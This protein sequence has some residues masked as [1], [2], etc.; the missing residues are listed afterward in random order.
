MRWDYVMNYKFLSQGIHVILHSPGISCI[1][2]VGYSFALRFGLQYESIRVSAMLI[3]NVI[4]KLLCRFLF[5]HTFV[6]V[7][8]NTISFMLPYPAVFL[9]SICLY[10]SISNSEYCTVLE[11]YPCVICDGILCLL[12]ENDVHV[13][14]LEPLVLQFFNFK[15]CWWYNSAKLLIHNASKLSY[16][17]LCDPHVLQTVSV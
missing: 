5:M 2:A 1:V 15:F 10:C 9:Q 13:N 7:L 12:I 17:L 14:H 6:L 4:N 8:V 16:P 11:W 3:H